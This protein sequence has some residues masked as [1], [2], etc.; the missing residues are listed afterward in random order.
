MAKQYGVGI[1][2]AGMIAEY[3]AQAIE[4]SDRTRLVAACA[5]IEDADAVNAF[6]AKHACKAY[7]DFN[8]MLK[9]D[10]IDIVTI[11]TPSGG[12]MEPAIAAA[13]AGKHALVE[14]PIE[15]TLDRIDRILAAHDKAGTTVGGFF[16]GRFTEPAGLL[17]EAVDQGRFG[18]MTFGMAFGPWWRDQSYYDEGGWKGTMRLDGGG[19]L[20]NQG[21]HTIDLLQW[22]MGPVESVS[23]HT[24]TLAHTNI[25]VEDTGAASI[26]FA[27][28]AIGM[29]G[30]ATSMWPGHFRIVEVS[31]DK[32]TVA[33]ADSKFLFWQFAEESDRD[34]QIRKE[35]VE[36]PGAGV[37]ASNPSAGL[38]SAGHQANLEQFIAAMEAGEPPPISGPDARRSVEI[39]LAIYASARDGRAVSL[40]L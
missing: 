32:G 17:R 29:V 26:R 5:R 15:I 14:K 9:D 35:F 8:E 28:G 12:H 25:E 3:H 24:A 37:G 18:R 39:I 38:T 20:M 34:E 7:T 31:G 19:A 1:I 4:G 27:N 36:F 21:I 13:Q 16:N 40:P 33:L 30:C 10:A 11:A 23:A 22:M 2:G 6:A